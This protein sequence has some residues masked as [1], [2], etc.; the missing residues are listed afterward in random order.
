MSGRK[1]ADDAPGWRSIGTI[2]NYYG[3][4]QIVEHDGAFWW[5]INNYDG[6]DAEQIPEYLYR[7]LE[8]FENERPKD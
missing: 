1:P 5:D 6:R 3:D 4:L 7:A 8:R 2:S